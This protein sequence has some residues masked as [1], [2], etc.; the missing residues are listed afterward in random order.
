MPGLSRTSDA[1]SAPWAQLAG[2]RAR[3][4]AARA[5]GQLG[6]AEGA[7]TVSLL[8]FASSDE[9]AASHVARELLG[10]RVASCKHDSRY[11]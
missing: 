8:I 11:Y 2:K 7:T 9:K 5:A 3:H 6:R 10:S 4:D 1:A